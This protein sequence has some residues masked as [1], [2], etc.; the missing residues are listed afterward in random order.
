[1]Q[2]ITGLPLP[3]KVITT[4][5]PISTVTAHPFPIPSGVPA[6]YF[7]NVPLE[8]KHSLSMD[9]KNYAFKTNGDASKIVMSNRSG[10]REV[11]EPSGISHSR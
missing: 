2:V 11:V 4:A 3:S 6:P 1:M 9:N 5:H 7:K 10:V 8:R